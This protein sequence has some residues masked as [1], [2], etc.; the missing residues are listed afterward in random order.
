M[1]I[2][3][4]GAGYV[5][6]VTAVCLSD[7]GF[8]VQVIE[9]DLDKVK[10][11]SN[12]ICTIYEPGLPNLIRK[13]ISKKRLFF[14]NNASLVL[15]NVDVIFICVGTPPKSDG[16]TDMSQIEAAINEIIEYSVEDD[17]K[18]IVIKSTV[19]VG[20][21]NW[22]RNYINKRLED[23][24]AN[25]DVVSNPEFLREGVAVQDF[26][27]PDRIV[28]GGDSQR[29]IEILSNVIYGEF[30]CPKIIAD[31]NTAEMI[32]YAANSFL[33]VKVSFINM[34]SDLCEKMDA[35]ILKVSEG[36]GYDVRISPHFLKAGIGFGG[37]CFPKDLKAFSHLGKKYNVNFGLL[38]EVLK[39]NEERPAKVI[40]KLRTKL[41]D[42]ND[43]N[44]VILGLTFKPNT[45]DV[46]ETPAA[47]L[48]EKLIQ[49]GA[50]IKAYDPAG[51][52]NFQQMYPHLSTRM[53]LC[54]DTSDL[55][56]NSH[57]VLLVTDWPEFR[58]LDWCSII[59][60]MELPILFDLRNLLD[61]NEMLQLGYDYVS[62][63]RGK[64][65]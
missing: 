31:S 55:F 4:Y 8:S 35:D 45:D 19:P 37:S 27:K 61:A 59:K 48:I 40:S 22:I 13:N 44:I 56:Y 49:N 28:I 47:K 42:L 39:I 32:K 62:I 25:I 34:V 17:Y 9:K 29:A 16:S 21:A 2:A 12:G 23:K 50:F 54:S 14:T 15:P 53:L 36:I 18:I 57:A 38:D 65:Q 63:G 60:I 41:G 7:L 43:K 10:K 26:F 64:Y 33:A 6:L 51:N 58:E 52:S 1:R 46:R 5:G 24:R 20:T 11:L 30:N 3:V